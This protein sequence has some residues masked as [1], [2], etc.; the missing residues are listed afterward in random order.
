M[1]PGLISSLRNLSIGCLHPLLGARGERLTH[2]LLLGHLDGLSRHYVRSE[3]FEGAYGLSPAE[4]QLEVDELAHHVL[5][6]HA[7]MI[8]G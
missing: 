6:A 8:R 3:I 4:V 2:Y 7:C 5:V 1:P